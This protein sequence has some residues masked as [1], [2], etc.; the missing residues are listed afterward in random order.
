MVEQ[1]PMTDVKELADRL[2]I[3]MA[4]IYVDWVI[5]TTAHLLSFCSC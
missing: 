4:I 1:D 5:E 3:E 2:A